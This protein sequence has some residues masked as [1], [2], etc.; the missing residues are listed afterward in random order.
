MVEAEER[1]RRERTRI[2]LFATML[3]TYGYALLGGALWEPLTKAQTLQIQNLVLA[4]IALSMHGVA[5]YIVPR[6][7][8][9]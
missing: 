8:A 4:A 3:V 5:L 6:G 9:K 1:A 2:K 7:E